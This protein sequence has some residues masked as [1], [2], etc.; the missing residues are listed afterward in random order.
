LPIFNIQTQKIN[1]YIVSFMVSLKLKSSK[2]KIHILDLTD[3]KYSS[4]YQQ[5][6]NHQQVSI[7][8]SLKFLLYLPGY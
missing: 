8:Y 7:I 1:F 3:D 4:T 6:L 2:L 5:Q